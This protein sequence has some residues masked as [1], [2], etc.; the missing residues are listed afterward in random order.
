MWDVNSWPQDQESH[1]LPTEP[2]RCPF[3]NY[4]KIVDKLLFRDAATKQ[5]I[6]D[7]PKFLSS[8][9]VKVGRFRRGILI[10]NRMLKYDCRKLLV[11]HMNCQYPICWA[12]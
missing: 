10:I 2:T 8:Y 3:H 9:I 12:K 7:K 5:S 11:S 6:R 4:F 1:S